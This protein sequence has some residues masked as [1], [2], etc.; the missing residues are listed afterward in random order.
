VSTAPRP[1]GPDPGH[2]DPPQEELVIDPD[3]PDP[4]LADLPETP[5]PPSRPRRGTS[6]VLAAAM[7]GLR[8]ALEGPKKETIVV[9]VDAAGDPPNIDVDGLDEHL[10]DAHRVSGPPL[11]DIKERGPARAPARRR[12]RR[13]S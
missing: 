13:L 7:L 10:G 8:D 4:L 1:D 9:Q 3:E 5:T 2:P 11:D 12:R 6:G